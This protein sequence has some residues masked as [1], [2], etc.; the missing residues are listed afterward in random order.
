MRATQYLGLVALFGVLGCG[1]G[2][3][4]GPTVARVEPFVK[5]RSARPRSDSPTPEQAAV[6]RLLDA[7]NAE[8][9]T[10]FETLVAES[11]P[12]DVKAMLKGFHEAT[13]KLDVAGCPVPVRAT[14]TKHL[15]AWKDLTS[16]IGRLPDTY[17]GVEFMDTLHSLFRGNAEKGKPLGGDVVAG[18]Q[19]VLKTTSELHTAVEQAG[20]SMS[21]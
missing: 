4:D 3:E 20:L 13:E 11:R 14:W 18:V 7:K 15:K 10:R 2:S 19:N 12:A 1:S 6:Q 17:E 21:K 9:R 16:A 5:E 8:F